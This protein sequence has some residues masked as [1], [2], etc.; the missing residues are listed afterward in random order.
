MEILV[1]RDRA[2]RIVILKQE[3]HIEELVEAS[4]LEEAWFTRVPMIPSVHR[5]AQGAET[6]QSSAI[7]E[8]K[9]LLGSRMHIVRK[10]DPISPLHL[11]TLLGL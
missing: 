3:R 10:L 2:R 11:H 5:D 1:Q 6:V 7:T 8:D 9:S 4:G